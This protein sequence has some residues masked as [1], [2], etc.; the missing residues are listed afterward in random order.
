MGHLLTGC[1][2]ACERSPGDAAFIV[3]FPAR[4]KRKVD[5]VACNRFGFVFR[6]AC[7]LILIVLGCGLAVGSFILRQRLIS[8]GFD[9]AS[10]E[11][12]VAK[13]PNRLLIVASALVVLGV[14]EI[15]WVRLRN[16]MD[17]KKGEKRGRK[18]GQVRRPS[19]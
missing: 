12:S 8:L 13:S 10:D 2:A 4:Y 19:G 15:V 14:L 11:G 17:R 3:S 7:G 18:S 1:G 5:E 6:S 9:L 16:G